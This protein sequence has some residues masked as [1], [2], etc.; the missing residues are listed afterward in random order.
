MTTEAGTGTG[1][2]FWLGG[3]GGSLKIW[4]SSLDDIAPGRE[5]DYWDAHAFLAQPEGL[6]ESLTSLP[7]TATV[8]CWSMGSLLLHRCL[9]DG[10]RT[11]AAL[12]SLC[13]IFCFVRPEGP[14]RARVLEAMIR[15]LELDREQLLERFWQSMMRG[16]EHRPAEAERWRRD[17]LAEAGK[18]P[19]K[20]LRQGLEY[21]ARAKASPE[22]LPSR[23]VLMGSPRDSIIPFTASQGSGK[24]N[25]LTFP[26][27]H[28]PFLTHPGSVMQAL[29]AASSLRQD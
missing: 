2:I 8:V 5:M 23:C 7:S 3:W 17:W 19:G 10:A 9:E 1:K 4:R 13:P 27:G 29:K 26:C 20:A 16:C 15:D 18:Q 6:S 14:W 22:A 11:D 24:R 28:L 21:L 25:A 12:V